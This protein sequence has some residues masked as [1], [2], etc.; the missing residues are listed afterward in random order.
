LPTGGRIVL[1]VADGARWLLLGSAAR[2]QLFRAVVDARS[3]RRLSLLWL[4]PE[5]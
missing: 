4:Q 1:V 3:G 2:G 5:G